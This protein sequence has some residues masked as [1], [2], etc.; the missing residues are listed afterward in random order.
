MTAQRNPDQPDLLSKAGLDRSAMITALASAARCADPVEQPALIEAM[1]QL[2]IAPPRLRE[3]LYARLLS[4]TRRFGLARDP[5]RQDALAAILGVW[6]LIPAD[7]RRV[8]FS[9]VNGDLETAIRQTATAGDPEARRACIAALRDLGTVDAIAALTP[10]LVDDEPRVAGAADKAFITLI[11][12]LTLADEPAIGLADM[13]MLGQIVLTAIQATAEHRCRGPVVGAMILLDPTRLSPASAERI[14]PLANWLAS[15]GAQAEPL[16]AALRG[17]RHPIARRRAWQWM[18]RQNLASACIDRLAR[19]HE[20]HEHEVVLTAMHLAA[21][22]RRAAAARDIARRAGFTTTSDRIAGG[23]VAASSPGIPPRS[24]IPQLAEIPDL[25][26]R[27]KWGLMRWIEVIDAPLRIR[28]AVLDPLLSDPMPGVR[29]GAA[30]SAHAE[31]LADYCFDE[32]AAVART[33]S[34]RWSRV[35]MRHK[36]HRAGD[37][38][39]RRLLERLARSPHAYVRRIAKDD[40]DAISGLS[41]SEPALGAG[42]IPVTVNAAALGD[43]AALIPALEQDLMFPEIDRARHAV[44]LVRRLGLTRQMQS[45]LSAIFKKTRAE[46]RGEQQEPDRLAA[47]VVAALADTPAADRTAECAGVL[48]AAIADHDDRVRANAVDG[49]A[50]EARRGS[51][52]SPLLVELK[53]DPHHRVRANA[54]RGLIWSEGASSAHEPGTELVAGMLGDHRPL[55]RLAG[56]WLCERW[57]MG[58]ACSAEDLRQARERLRDLAEHDLDPRVI[59]R[60]S[61]TARRIAVLNSAE[62]MQAAAAGAEA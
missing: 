42:G 58:R 27:A 34:L 46:A 12:R 40:L 6:D 19:T 32:D 55:H 9:A 8:M 36:T 47:T 53:N 17:S 38:S 44:G 33:A 51:A 15:A 37:Q 29:L 18:S 49:L 43:P 24:A 13:T 10:L 25:P 7:Y 20:P 14:H 61:R 45:V 54:L 57:A 30:R 56:V 62:D 11:E 52:A 22:P 59:A 26:P 3:T 41:Y 4:M 31:D 1:A 23:E 21:N 5:M 35:G 39:H 50:R 48:S 28:R 16:R 2:F 60:A